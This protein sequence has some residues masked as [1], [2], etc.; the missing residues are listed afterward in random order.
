MYSMYNIVLQTSSKAYKR[1]EFPPSYPTTGATH[2][3]EGRT[4]AAGRENCTLSNTYDL[5]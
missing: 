1:S 5:I 3:T 2:R 4:G